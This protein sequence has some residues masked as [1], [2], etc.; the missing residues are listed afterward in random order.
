MIRCIEWATGSY[1]WDTDAVPDATVLD[2]RTAAVLAFGEAQM[3]HSLLLAAGHYTRAE[4]AASTLRLYEAKRHALAAIAAAS[5]S[6]HGA[7]AGPETRDQEHD[8]DHK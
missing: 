8:R 7:D 3:S 1:T 2:A 5:I 4:F 6:G